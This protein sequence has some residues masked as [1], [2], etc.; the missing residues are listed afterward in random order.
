MSV[1]D[2][3]ISIKDIRKEAENE[4]KEERIVTAKRKM[5]AKLEA[6]DNAERILN[7]LKREL[8]ELEYELSQG[9]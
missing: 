8:E 5:K 9:I 3:K 2:M 7:N 6:I 1:T 4:L